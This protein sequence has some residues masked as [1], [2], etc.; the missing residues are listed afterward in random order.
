MKKH[1][2]ILPAIALTAFWALSWT[3]CNKDC[4]DYLFYKVPYSISPMKDTFNV[5]DSIWVNLD[6]K[7]ELTDENGGVT[8]VFRNY[9]FR[10]RVSSDKMD[11]DPPLAQTA[12]F[13][14]L[15][16]ITGS[17]S[18][19]SLPISNISVF[20]I[21]TV[22]LVGIY[23]YQGVFIL[24]EKGLFWFGLGTT[25]DT[26][27]FG[28]SGNCSKVPVYIGS[29]VTNESENN[30]HMLQWAANSA[31]HN[32]DAKRFSDYGGYCFVVE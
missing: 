11:I 15:H 21:S 1:L 17:D 14:D 22:E 32:I 26:G 8:N 12:N 16:S 4:P 2:I 5:G 7:E 10:F 18:L 23:K 24:K 3:S 19:I 25:S 28:I 30:Y 31:Y 20:S 6:F 27:K 13:F 29:R 9:D